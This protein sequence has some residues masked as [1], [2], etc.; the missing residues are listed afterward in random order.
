MEAAPPYQQ[1]SPFLLLGILNPKS[2]TFNSQP[3]ALNPTRWFMGSCKGY[4]SSNMGYKYSY[5][6][7][8]PIYNC[9]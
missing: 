2:Q 8:N 4:K 9:P 1:G 6:T 3:E 7:Y 5:P